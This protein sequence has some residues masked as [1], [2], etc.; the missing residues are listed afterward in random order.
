MK[1][2]LS[3]YL[4]PIIFSSAWGVLLY[5]NLTKS[6]FV[7]TLAGFICIL[8]FLSFIV[9]K[10]TDWLIA[11]SFLYFSISPLPQMILTADFN[12][13]F[14]DQA[15]LT[16]QAIISQGILYFILTTLF[17]I[18]F[19][20]TKM[21]ERLFLV[22]G[23]LNSLVIIYKYLS[24]QPAWFLFNNPAID[25]S[26][27]ACIIPLALKRHLTLAVPLAIACLLTDS[28]SGVAGVMIALTVY[29]LSPKKILYGLLAASVALSFG[30]L[31]QG[32]NKLLDSSGRFYVWDLGMKFW[33]TSVN[34][35]FG[36]GTGTWA[37][38]GPTLQVMEAMRN[39]A[40]HVDGFFWMH[41]DPLQILFENGFIGLML[42][43]FVACR[44]VWLLR[45][46]KMLASCFVT[47]VSLSFIQM[48][49]RHIL[50]TMLGAWLVK[51]SI[52][53]PNT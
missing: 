4:P 48:P 39:K 46:N 6:F 37:V 26:F 17:I 10:K 31:T 15:I 43:I 42:V 16:F 53:A 8:L 11:T 45:H 19:K 2:L 32:Y 49:L 24:G 1:N 23:L 29:Y 28:S 35:L 25:A 30:I 40:S 3:S 21:L 50:F 9:Y 38:Y 41:N 44:T 34:H 27:M 7:Q 36:A 47:F 13:N 33:T 22:F 52:K 51:E 12:P 14:N 18:F 20:N 5:L